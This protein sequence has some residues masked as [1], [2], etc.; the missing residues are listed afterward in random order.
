MARKR[1]SSIQTGLLRE[2]RE[3]ALNAVQAFNNPRATFK[4]ETFIVLMVIAWTRLLHAYYRREGV[5]Y[6]YFE[7]GP[8]RRRF[9][10]LK[11]GAFKYWELAQCLKDGHSPL[12]A[13]TRKNLEFLIGLR[14]EV[15]HHKSAGV[16]EHFSAP[17]GG[18]LAP[19]SRPLVP[20]GLPITGDAAG[21]G[22]AADD[23]LSSAR[24]SRR[25]H[26]ARVQIGLNRLELATRA[27]QPSC[28]RRCRLT[29]ALA[30]LM[31]VCLLRLPVL[32][33]M[34]KYWYT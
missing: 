5:E 28:H 2:S 30:V 3:A 6:R 9:T 22:A 21:E 27:R 7:R 25:A 19:Q 8:K 31:R 1:G 15:E 14:G 12:D 26:R 17:G 10:R 29:Q 11:S 32:D 33:M 18:R 4:T 16:D 23:P 34:A 13:P 20:Q 24:V